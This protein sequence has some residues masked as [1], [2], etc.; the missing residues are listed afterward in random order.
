[1]LID[2]LSSPA[3]T[4]HFKKIPNSNHKKSSSNLFQ[5]TGTYNK[6]LRAAKR[7]KAVLENRLKRFRMLD[8]D[9]FQEM[10]KTLSQQTPNEKSNGIDTMNDMQLASKFF[11]FFF[12]YHFL[13]IFFSIIDYWSSK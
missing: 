7:I 9:E 11:L 3:H 13:F 10:L 5:S 6:N 4:H 1:M 2:R 12:Y 8:Q